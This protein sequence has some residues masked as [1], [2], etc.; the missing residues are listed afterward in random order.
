MLVNCDIYRPLSIFTATIDFMSSLRIPY[1]LGAVHFSEG[2]AAKFGQDSETISR[3]LHV[4]PLARGRH[5]KIGYCRWGVLWGRWRW[6]PV[7]ILRGE[8]RS[9][10]NHCLHL[11]D[12]H[13]QMKMY[14]SW[15]YAVKV[16]RHTPWS[17]GPL[18]WIPGMWFTLCQFRLS[19]S[20]VTAQ[21]SHNSE[22]YNIGVHAQ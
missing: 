17:R 6:V 22:I 18:S 14:K 7:W 5:P 10:R 21:S 12:K 2:P 16:R 9:M 8:V 11:W 19:I 15:V 1:C 13:L 20:F 4:V 3:E